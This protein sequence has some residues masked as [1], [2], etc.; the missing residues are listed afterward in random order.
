MFSLAKILC[1]ALICASPA[2]S[3]ETAPQE[4]ILGPETNLPMPRFVS[5][6]S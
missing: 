1:V 2:F 4:V 6:K 3:Q 5:L